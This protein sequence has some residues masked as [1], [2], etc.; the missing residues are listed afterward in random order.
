MTFYLWYKH[1]NEYTWF[2]SKS[3]ILFWG[4]FNFWSTSTPDMCLVVAHHYSLNSLLQVP[5]LTKKTRPVVS[6]IEKVSSPIWYFTTPNCESKPVSL[7]LSLART[8]VISLRPTS[9]FSV[10]SIQSD[11]HYHQGFFN[12][13]EQIMPYKKINT[14]IIII[15]RPPFRVLISLKK[16]FE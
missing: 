8:T 14:V 13:L 9:V 6:S 16:Y 2:K 11:G 12:W 5:T 7:S 3:A 15:K 10:I 1:K 4:W